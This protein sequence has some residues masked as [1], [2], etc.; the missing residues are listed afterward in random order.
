MM[1]QGSLATNDLEVGCIY[2][3]RW[4]YIAW[5]WN[6]VGLLAIIAWVFAIVGLLFTLLWCCNCL[7]ISANT[8][9]RGLDI[10]KHGREAYI[11]D[12]GYVEPLIP[13]RPRTP[14]PIPEEIIVRARPFDRSI[15]DDPAGI[16]NSS[17]LATE[18]ELPPST[19]E[20]TDMSA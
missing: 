13:S 5:C 9:V 1:Q 10:K 12:P 19:F 7:R 15:V 11:M 3:H 6:F 20:T 14:T 16:P 17:F 4:A 2:G 18:P 8:E